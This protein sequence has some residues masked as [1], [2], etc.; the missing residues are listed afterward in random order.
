MDGDQMQM[1]TVKPPPEWVANVSCYSPQLLLDPEY[2][3]DVSISLV[4]V[5]KF[6]LILGVCF[7]TLITNVFF[8]WVINSC[9]GTVSS[10]S[11]V[12]GGIGPAHRG[13]KGVG[14]MCPPPPALVNMEV[15]ECIKAQPRSIL[16]SLAVCHLLMEISVGFLSLYPVLFRCWPFGRPLCQ[17]QVRFAPI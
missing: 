15:A 10:S 3:D 13:C 9:T 6:L 4:D 11:K 5:I 1:N 17:L 12:G 16:I 7:A 8:I 2:S 14:G